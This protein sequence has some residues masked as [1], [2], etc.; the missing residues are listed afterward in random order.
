MEWYGN[1]PEPRL[2][3][4]IGC[5]IWQGRLDKKGYGH[6]GDGRIASRVVYEL[7]IGP[8][9]LEYTIDHLCEIT[10]CVN[11]D[12]LEAVTR[13]E[14]SRRQGGGFDEYFGCGHARTLENTSTRRRKNGNIKTFC[15]LC[16]NARQRKVY[17]RQKGK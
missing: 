9:P 3:I 13:V 8:I 15:R 6:L 5:L 16:A 1:V 17:Y 11:P 14:N 2:F 4:P 10:S 7:F 12:H